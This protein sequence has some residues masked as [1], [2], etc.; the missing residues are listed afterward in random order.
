M[1]G[2][3]KPGPFFVRPGALHTR[4]VVTLDTT[5]DGTAEWQS[6]GREDF[7]EVVVFGSRPTNFY[8]F[9]GTLGTRADT[10]P[11]PPPVSALEGYSSPPPRGT[12]SLTQAFLE[13]ETIDNVDGD[14]LAAIYN[15]KHPP[16]FQRLL[17][18]HPTKTCAFF[19]AHR[20]G[21]VPQIDS[22]EKWRS[23]IATAGEWTTASGISNT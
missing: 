4:P 20:V 22:P 2:K 23:S 21:A 3:F 12:R 9:A 13:S 14:V 19:M 11:R 8:Q 10:R 6:D 1:V 17:E 16:F 18:A 15:P 7:T 5:R